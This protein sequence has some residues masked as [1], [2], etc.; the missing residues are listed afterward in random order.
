VPAAGTVGGAGWSGAADRIAAEGGVVFGISGFE[1]LIIIAFV[2]IIFGPDKLPE[3]A[4]TIG[5]AMRV[6][7]SAQADMERVIKAEMLTGGE[8]KFSL[9]DL[10]TGKST[11]SEPSESAPVADSA[12]TVTTANVAAANAW[13]ST[14]E[15]DE[16]EDEE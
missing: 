9:D 2:L 14:S 12:T 5:S 11:A 3:V 7:K 10:L 1:L 4:K 16:E 8:S 15:E 6:F 13:A